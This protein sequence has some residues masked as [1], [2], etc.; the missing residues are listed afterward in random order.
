MSV[1]IKFRRGNSSEWVSSGSTV[2]ASGE[3]GFE[4]DTGRFKIGDGITAWSGLHYAS[5][6]PTGFIAGSGI[7]IDLG[8]NGSYAT[9]S[10]TGG[11]NI[12]NYGDNRLLTSD[13]TITGINGENNLTFDGSLLSVTGS[14][15]FVS[16]LFVNNIPVSISGHTHTSSQITNFNSSV[17]GLLPIVSGSEYVVSSFL[18]NIYTISVTGLQPSGIYASGTHTHTVSQ[19]TDFNSGVSGLLPAVTG[20]GYIVSSFNNNTYTINITGLQ[21]TGNYSLV[22]HTHTSSD[23]TDFNSVVSGL[24][25][26]KNISSG[27]GINVSSTTGNFI[28]SVSGL[29]STYISDFNEAI[30]DRIGSGL[31]VAGTGINLNYNDVA[32]TFTVSVTGVSF[33]GHTHTASNI[34]DFNSAVS[35]LLPVKNIVAGTGI[36]VSSVSG[37]YTITSTGSGVIA[38][39]ATQSASVVTTVFNKTASTIPKMS[40]VY[41]NGGQ[42]DQ[43]TI[44]LAIATGDA[45][46]AG[47]YGLTFEPISSM[48]TGKVIVF[49]A[50]TGVNTDQFNPTAPAGNVNGTVLYLSPSTSGTLTTTKPSAPNHIVAL[51]TIVRTHQ[52]EGVIEVRVQNGFELDELHNVAISGATNGQ[53]LQYNSGTQ[54]WV[55]SSS[56]NFSTL[57]LNGTTVSVVGHTHTASQ[58]TDFNEAV[59]D[60]IGSGLFVAG[61]GVNLNY[62]DG[63]NSFTVSITGLINNPTNN[64]IL[65]SRDNTT[66]GIDAESNLTFDGTSLVV[67]GDATVDNLKLDGNILSSTNSNGN[68]IIKPN[69]TG[70]LQISDG[71]DT[72]GTNSIDF[73]VD[74]TLSTHVASGGRSVIGGG[75]LN[76][77]SGYASVVGGGSGNTSSGTGSIVGGGLINTSSSYASVIGGGKNNTASG[78]TSTVGGGHSNTAS[79][80]YSTVGGGNGNTSS[81]SRSTVGGGQ[82]NTASSN[83]STVG[84]GISNTA[85][86]HKS[87]ICGGDTNTASGS[88]SNGYGIFGHQFVGGGKSNDVTAYFGTI[89]GGE[90]NTVSGYI[91][92]QYAPVRGHG[93]ICGGKNNTVSGIYGYIG[94]G[95][96]N[97]VSANYSGITDK[98]HGT[99]GGGRNNTVSIYGYYGTVSGGYV[100]TASNSYSTVGGGLNNTASGSLSKVGGGQSNTASGTLSTVGGGFSNTAGGGRSTISGG[101]ANTISGS[102]S[103]ISGGINNSSSGSSSVIG[104]G[105]GHT[106]S[107][108]YSTISGGHSNTTSGNASTVGGGLGN[109][110]SGNYS[111]I[112]G[113]MRAKATRYGELSHAAGYFASIGDAQHTILVA[114]RTTTNATANQVLLLDNSAA[115]LTLPAETTW[116]FSIK[117]SAYNDTDNEG[118]WWI[119]RGGIRRN[120]AN[121]T[122]LIGSLIT[123]S[124]T[125]SSLSTASASVVADDTNEALEIRVTGVASKNIRWVAVVDISQVSYGTP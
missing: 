16:G 71:G 60:R 90:D 117:L 80:T 58:I 6:V 111:T 49:G 59:D 78:T 11:T 30:D 3:P 116:T 38:D 33:S 91:N 55:P 37:I 17:S 86:G 2:L 68:I 119:F 73:Q 89:G 74:R 72:R 104:G 70:A 76:T 123:E 40:A 25:P 57:Q 92:E 18:N 43:P 105:Y 20:T 44:Q 22:G 4:L 45:T 7:D 115:R 47:T 75:R 19:I 32:N 8:T 94:G 110:S 102:Y 107:G 63:S 26:V 35:G 54:L 106:G 118:G 100:N 42:G 10:V 13:G 88:Y 99:I 84:G 96:S 83:Y 64:R 120:A 103:T 62:N 97:T 85:S 67:T 122:A 27:S 23:I 121:G 114:R 113:G 50:L 29:N 51:G 14:G 124:G 46:S 41:I 31:F 82:T 112:P 9:I 95:Q 81:G 5:I 69:G 61:T 65:T 109:T 34:T 125:E 15:N 98:G 52:N 66:T 87:T 101:Y 77:A 56:G 24:L 36:S 1:I 28:I 48:G 108:N 21:P 12:S 39:S 53:F 93:A 79:S